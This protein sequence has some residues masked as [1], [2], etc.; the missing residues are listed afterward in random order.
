MNEFL[1]E[2]Y[3]E[4]IPSSAQA[5]AKNDLKNLFV[6][7][8]KNEKINFSSIETFATARRITVIIKGLRNKEIKLTKEIRGPSTSAEKKAV[9]GFLK[10]QG[11]KN[12]K[13][14]LKKTVKGKEYFF[15]EKKIQ[16][17]SL[18][19]LFKSEMFSILS[20][21]KWKK[22]M[23][24]SSFNEKW[25]RPIKSIL[26]I[27]NEKIINFDYA[28]ISSGNF[29]Y[30]NYYYFQK[31]IKCNNSN[32]YKKALRKNFVLL[33]KKE[34]IKKIEVELEKFC[35][36]NKLKLNYNQELMSR[37]SDSVEWPNVFF[38]S[39]S[40]NFFDLPD[41]LITTILSEKQD[42]FSFKKKNGEL[43]NFFSFVSNL[44]KK[45]KRNLINGN[46]NVLK[47]RFKDA[48]FF[49]E[50]DNK[51]KLSERLKKLSSIVFYNDLGTLLERSVRIQKLCLKISQLLKLDI[52]ENINNL[53]Y[54]NVDLTTELVRE[55]PSLQGQVGGF[56]ARL[57]GI[58]E[59][60]CNAFSTQ[61]EFS[62]KNIEDDL[63]FILS[64]SQ[65]VD[66]LFG[67]FASDRKVS[68]SGDPFGVR[69]MA[70]SIINMLIEKK[71]SLSFSFIFEVL[72]EIYQSQN[73]EIKFNKLKVIEFLNKR[74]EILLTERGYEINTV[75]SCIKKEEFD[76]SDTFANIERLKE[77]LIS[78]EGNEFIKSYKRLESIINQQEIDI[79]IETK[80]F[81]K[82]EEEILYKDMLS[83][84]KDY[85]KNSEVLNKQSFY[86]LSKSINNFL[87]NVIVNSSDE[88]IK[89]NRVS[90][91]KDC[92]KIINNFFKFSEL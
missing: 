37:V 54:S 28:G 91:L 56:Y 32:N 57:F 35:E 92:E 75:K 25:S 63:S 82:N 7:F 20:S 71:K 61:Y 26:C 85:L 70:L 10:S 78:T 5:I 59:K 30:G 16:Q 12:E 6:N 40:E 46:Q 21:I 55:Y 13:L 34:R 65:K 80:L 84:K 60:C 67:F 86:D 58:N 42:N 64:L 87:D 68:G 73:I 45:K 74:F 50:E 49:I 90:L 77:F 22:S 39:F 3:G 53:L 69:R 89:C 81:Q 62:K 43:S 47:A 72:V 88:K 76:P 15:F 52:R 9:E 24:W 8:L 29:T 19:E 48:K 79:K 66:S 14:L 44:E 83:L 4:E 1:L 33:D 23:R 18:P 2:I 11:I 38:G 31:K 41:F 51:V 27:L 17:K 36:K